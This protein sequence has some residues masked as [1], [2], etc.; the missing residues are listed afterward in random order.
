MRISARTSSVGTPRSFP[1]N[2]PRFAVLVFD[3]GAEIAQ[4]LTVGGV[5]GE[6]LVGERQVV[7]RDD[8][9]DDELRAI[10]PL[11]AT[12]AMAALRP[13]RQIE[14]VDLEIRAGQI[15]ERHVERGVE[16]IAPALGQMRE[17][18]LFVSQQRS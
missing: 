4:R 14:S 9:R 13:F 7:W 5:A 15:V 3:L 12:I 18:S 6:N 10:G 8:Q 1:P 17:Q 16:Q 11:V 2:A